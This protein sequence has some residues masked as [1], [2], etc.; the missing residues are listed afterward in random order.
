MEAR[1]CEPSAESRSQVRGIKNP[2]RGSGRAQIA[3]FNFANS[4]IWKGSSRGRGEPPGHAP[5]T[6]RLLSDNCERK[7]YVH[8]YP[9]FVASLHW[10]GSGRR[11]LHHSQLDHIYGGLRAVR[12]HHSDFSLG[13]RSEEHTSELQSRQY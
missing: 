8:V 6:L 4:L 11:P 1:V 7:E 13:A 3:S 5:D 12:S 2:A 9:P 10:L